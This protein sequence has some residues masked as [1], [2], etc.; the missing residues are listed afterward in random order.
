MNLFDYTQSGEKSPDRK[1][2]GCQQYYS[3]SKVFE[4]KA[5]PFGKVHFVQ[6]FLPTLAGKCLP[7]GA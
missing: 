3:I 4:S 1:P 7:C 5:L 2:T 6:K